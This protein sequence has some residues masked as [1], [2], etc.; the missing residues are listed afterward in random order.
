M[1][2]GKYFSGFFT[3]SLTRSVN[4]NQGSFE[5][6]ES[7][8]LLVLRRNNDGEKI[9]KGLKE[10][11]EFNIYELTDVN[12]PRNLLFLV[13]S[14]KF[15][16]EKISKKAEELQ[17]KRDN[18]LFW[19]DWPPSHSWVFFLGNILFYEVSQFEFWENVLVNIIALHNGESLFELYEK[20]TRLFSINGNLN[21]RRKDDSDINFGRIDENEQFSSIPRLFNIL[22]E[23]CDYFGPNI[24]IIFWLF[25]VFLIVSMSIFSLNIFAKIIDF[26]IKYLTIIEWQ[27]DHL[28]LIT[29]RITPYLIL[30]IPIITGIGLIFLKSILDDFPLPKHD[31]ER[32]MYFSK[33]LWRKNSERNS[34]H[35]Q[36][37]INI[38]IPLIMILIYFPISNNT[39]I[40]KEDFFQFIFYFIFAS[41]S[42]QL[43]RNLNIRID[44]SRETYETFWSFKLPLI[45]KNLIFF[46]YWSLVNRFSK[47][48]Y[49][50]SFDYFP[51]AVSLVIL[52]QKIF[53]IFNS[54]PYSK[55]S[56][57]FKLG[58]K[59]E[60]KRIPLGDYIT[61]EKELGFGRPFV[62][63]KYI[64]NS[65]FYFG[66]ESTLYED[67]WHYN[68]LNTILISICTEYPI[69][70][71]FILM[72][73]NV[74]TVT[75][76][77]SKI[78]SDSTRP[79]LL[80]ITLSH[81]LWK[82]MIDSG[83]LFSTSCFSSIQTSSNLKTFL[84]IVTF[85]SNYI[86][87]GTSKSGKMV[88]LSENLVF[89]IFKLIPL[90]KYTREAIENNKVSLNKAINSVLRKRNPQIIKAPDNGNI[91]IS[92]N[93]YCVNSN[94]RSVELTSELKELLEKFEGYWILLKSNSDSL[95]EI[96]AALG[97]SWFIRRAVEKLNPVVH[98]DVDKIR[99]IVSIST[100]LIMGLNNRT[101]LIINKTKNLGKN[102][103]EEIESH[104]IEEFRTEEENSDNLG[105]VQDEGGNYRQFSNRRK[106][107]FE[108]CLVFDQP[109][110]TLEWSEDKTNIILETRQNREGFKMIETR[111]IIPS[112]KL[113]FKIKGNDGK[114]IENRRQDIL[115]YKVILKGGKRNSN[116][117]NNLLV[118]CRYFIK[119]EIVKSKESSSCSNLSTRFG[120]KTME[121]KSDDSDAIRKDTSSIE[122]T[123]PT[124]LG[125]SN[126][127]PLTVQQLIQ[128][129][130][131]VLKIV[132]EKR[133]ELLQYT[134]KMV[135]EIDCGYQNWTLE[136]NSNGMK[137]YKKEMGDQPFMSC[138]ITS[139]LLDDAKSELHLDSTNDVMESSNKITS[140]KDIVD[141]IWDPN[142]KMFY[143]PMVEKSD[144][145]HYFRN[146]NNICIFYQAFKGQ[147]GV[148]GRD[149]VVICYRIK[150]ETKESCNPDESQC[151]YI[152]TQS[153]EWPVINSSY[154]RAKN[155][156]ATY[157][158]RH[159]D[160]KKVRIFYFNQVDLHT[161]ISAWIIKRVILDQM[162]SLT[163]LRDALQKK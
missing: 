65:I 113:P 75:I 63:P 125:E 118:C 134:K 20:S 3:H 80:N 32:L 17:P 90:F 145:M 95:H 116:N 81:Q 43:V 142:N 8:F 162:N 98:Y 12:A 24:M 30:T 31:Q 111:S 136:R 85:T 49:E 149:F 73:N 87:I 148:S 135:S 132:M 2:L 26:T 72:I 147:W 50:N 158:F 11:E 61:Y 106:K 86:N 10:T 123:K 35:V 82:F 109:N 97:V 66:N 107:S 33:N 38:S 92:L 5:D 55:N 56:I 154:V 137:V 40:L 104:R 83:I 36:L 58:P 1:D 101:T 159:E 7:Y 64:W 88:Y 22:C 54:I 16:N 120:T 23:W 13:V 133:A 45:T 110:T 78:L 69:I 77:F 138:G 143:D 57:G 74:L 89:Y 41:I 126:E 114:V 29:K 76:L 71:S 4:E 84:F 160:E 152:L 6:R 121:F 122:S 112:Y 15:T 102:S 9:Y 119:T 128:E 42:F 53:S 127:F 115:C 155:Y 51:F 79:W 108:K 94:L 153:I 99:G 48:F 19:G 68:L 131:N 67:M 27:S 156:F 37:L 139:I 47:Y 18:N 14:L 105:V 163:M 157:V 44:V 28:V 39:V 60:M 124:F 21:G 70:T 93:R 130:D 117:K 46:F 151:E 129:E 62:E 34:N 59:E 161:D 100:T 150:S 146:D 91:G 96:N 140:I 52:T 144:P 25:L 103:L 141:Y